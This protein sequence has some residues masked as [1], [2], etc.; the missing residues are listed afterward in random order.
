MPQL[1]HI[2][3]FQIASD[4]NGSATRQITRQR[5]HTTKSAAVL[6]FI[7]LGMSGFSLKQLA[8]KSRKF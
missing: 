3:Y 1:N 4:L 7:G 6:A 8:S 2:F 5:D